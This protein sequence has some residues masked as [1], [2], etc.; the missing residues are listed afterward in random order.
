MKATIYEYKAYKSYILDWM[1]AA[2]QQGRGLRK[3]L[4]EAIG[5][6]MAFVTHV[7][8]GDYNFS[9]EQAEACARWIGLDDEA[10]DFFLLLV[11]YERAGTKGLRNQLQRQISSKRQEQA[12]LK[13]RVKI[14]E[15][16]SL[17]DQMTY[18]SSWHYA[19]FHMA[20]MN[21][22]LASIEELQ[23][24]FH[25]PF[26]K[27]MKVLEFLATRGFI[28]MAGNK[29]KVLKPVLHLELTSP[30]LKQHHTHWRLRALE[31]VG[32]REHDSLHYSGVISLSAED[33]EWVREK[34]SYLLK[35][36][37]EKLGS[38]PDEKLACL[39]FDWFQI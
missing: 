38:S 3:Q 20:L 37:I 10:S 5:C 36:V 31:S 19:A 16:L 14:A 1:A 30:L 4:A 29:I 6:Q 35:E 32:A 28:S 23:K 8:S 25:L 11:M 33:Y 22:N 21:P 39:N 24:Y 2:P 34:L 17:E 26:S 7:L 9:A 15:T 13:N 12:V 18:Y 27:V